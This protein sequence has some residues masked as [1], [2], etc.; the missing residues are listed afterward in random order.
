[1]TSRFI[2]GSPLAAA[3]LGASMLSLCH[4]AAL[5]KDAFPTTRISMGAGLMPKEGKNLSGAAC[6]P[7][8]PCLLVGDEMRFARLFALAPDAT[9]PQ[10]I[11]PGEPL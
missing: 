8:G 11:S 2:L 10:G 9:E 6:A 3:L 7:N 5:A 1:M 4:Q